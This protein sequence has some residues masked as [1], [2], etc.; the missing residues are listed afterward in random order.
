MTLALPDGTGAHWMCHYYASA[1]LRAGFRVILVVGTLVERVELP[2]AGQA[3]LHEL[4]QRGATVRFLEGYQKLFSWGLIRKL[5][6]LARQADVIVAFNQRDRKYAIWAGLLAG[7]PVIISVQNQ[8]RFRGT[9][10]VRRAKAFLYGVLVR[11]ARLLVCTSEVVREEVTGSF[12]VT[13]RRIAVLP[14]GIRPDRFEI[15]P[16]PGRPLWAKLGIRSDERVAVNV[17]RLDPQKGQDILLEAFAGADCPDMRLCL[18]GG[19]TEGSAYA[20][21]LSEKIARLGLGDRV[22]M[23]GWRDDTPQLLAEAD[24]YVHAA[25]WEGWSL[26]VLEA[27]AAGLPIVYTDCSGRVAG[28]QEG[29]HGW[30]V[31]TGDVD[32]LRAAL[33]RLAGLSAEQRICMGQEARA[34]VHEHY[35]VDRVIAPKFVELVKSALRIDG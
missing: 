14:N 19:A 26:A 28:F 31:R 2:R 22:L 5:K 24:V 33:E 3:L 29:I 23:V 25:R 7:V 8:H 4:E 21:Q 34:L 35:D 32:D 1:F 30:T 13:E 27:M 20:R 10:F 15:S 6:A 18:V 16:G 9:P 12:G 11:R 17:G